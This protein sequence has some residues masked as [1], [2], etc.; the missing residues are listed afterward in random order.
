MAISGDED[1]GRWIDFEQKSG[2]TVTDTYK[3]VQRIINDIGPGTPQRRRLFTIDNLLA[4]KNPAVI[5]LI[6]ES[7][8]RFYFR[9]PYYSVDGAIEYVFDTIQR[10]LEVKLDEIKNASDLRNEVFNIV[11]AIITFCTYFAI[12]GIEYQS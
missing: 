11:G 6:F 1:G 12:L 5:N 10:D 7:G 8:H 2:T 9:A 4:H 3:F